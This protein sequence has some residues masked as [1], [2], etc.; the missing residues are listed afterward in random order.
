MTASDPRP[1]SHAKA[2]LPAVL[3]LQL[4]ASIFMV[5]VIW[6]V[7]LVHY[8]LMAGWPHDDFPRWEAAHRQQT[9]FVVVPA[10]LAEG[11]AVVALLARRPAGV[12]AGMVWSGA[13]L[14][15]AIWGST[16]GIQVP[17]HEKLATGWDRAAHAALVQSNWLRTV[18]WSAR[19]LL[20]VAMLRQA[21][22][23][24]HQTSL[25]A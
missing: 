11:I 20:A 1:S 23:V 17:L 22:L 25:S 9:G 4:F 18:L 19:G 14:L 7:Q 2:Q 10:M 16:F 8:P 15:L 5:G 13:F 6:Y 3:L 24:S 21:V 12:P